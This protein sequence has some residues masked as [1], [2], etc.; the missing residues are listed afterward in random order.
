MSG[1]DCA[2]AGQALQHP[3]AG[4]G[5]GSAER[6]LSRQINTLV[7][8]DYIGR[9]CPVKKEGVQFNFQKKY[10]HIY[11]NSRGNT[12]NFAPASSIQFTIITTHL[13][14]IRFNIIAPSSS[15]FST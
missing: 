15:M 1:V 7:A 12:K 2:L 9:G 10:T 11:I 14:K 5:A 13:H 8:V 6:T 4:A 3:G